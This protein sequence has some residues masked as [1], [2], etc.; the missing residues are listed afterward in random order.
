MISKRR[1]RRSRNGAFG[2]MV[3]SP[4]S[5][6]S[7]LPSPRRKVSSAIPP[8]VNVSVL[9]TASHLC[10]RRRTEA[11]AACGRLPPPRLASFCRNARHRRAARRASAVPGPLP[12]F[13]REHRKRKLASFCNFARRRRATCRESTVRG[14][15]P[16]FGRDDGKPNWLCF[17]ILAAPVYIG[18]SFRAASGRF[19]RKPLAGGANSPKRPVPP[20]PG[21]RLSGSPNRSARR[22]PSS[23]ALSLTHGPEPAAPTHVSYLRNYILAI[24]RGMRHNRP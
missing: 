18:L 1:A 12:R 21:N 5:S 16:G 23:P 15:A 11:I 6:R 17:V 20:G 10:M 4:C 7:L 24:I 3:S 22:S 2:G 13:G 14:P 19:P 9:L 8:M